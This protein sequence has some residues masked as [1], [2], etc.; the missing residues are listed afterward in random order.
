M[1]PASDR[2]STLV[3]RLAIRFP[4]VAALFGIEPARAYAPK[5]P[6]AAAAPRRRRR[7][8]RP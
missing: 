7:G 3:R 1:T 8:R 6:R 5:A 4:A 2:F